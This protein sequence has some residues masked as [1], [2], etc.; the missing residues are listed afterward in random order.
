MNFSSD[1]EDLSDDSDDV[2]ND[3]DGSGEVSLGEDGYF[4]NIYT[5]NLFVNW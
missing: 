3:F 1:E 4:G 5:S 2:G